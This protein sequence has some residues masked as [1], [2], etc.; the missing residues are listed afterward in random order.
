MCPNLQWES[1]RYK[2][3]RGIRVFLIKWLVRVSNSPNHIEITTGT[4]IV[5]QTLCNNRGF[6]YQD[7]FVCLVSSHYIYTV[8]MMYMILCAKK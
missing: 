6:R 5:E 8:S 3:I 7:R 2:S 1:E 4:A